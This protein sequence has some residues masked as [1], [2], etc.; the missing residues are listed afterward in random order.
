V[1]SASSA[2]ATS[3]E[4]R[5]ETSADIPL[6]SI[7]GAHAW[8]TAPGGLSAPDLSRGLPAD[9]PFVPLGGNSQHQSDGRDG[10]LVRRDDCSSCPDGLW[11]KYSSARHLCRTSSR[12][13]DWLEPGR[14]THEIEDASQQSHGGLHV[15]AIAVRHPVGDP[16][17]R[18]GAREGRLDCPIDPGVSRVDDQ[19]AVRYAQSPITSCCCVARW[20]RSRHDSAP[21]VSWDRCR[22]RAAVP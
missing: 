8:K 19:L 13:E 9:G 5:I 17:H 4:R 10:L 20:D 16:E 12:S 2:L 7:R 11:S 14:W 1:I 21:I 18:S 15:K 22:R 3:G 6:D